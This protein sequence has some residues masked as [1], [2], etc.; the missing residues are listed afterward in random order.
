MARRFG[1][2][3]AILVITFSLNSAHKGMIQPNLAHCV[4]RNDQNNLLACYS[5]WI[6]YFCIFVLA[7]K[8]SYSN[9]L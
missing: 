8:E 7:A 5:K 2:N 3:L 6:M 9:V 1:L 4:A